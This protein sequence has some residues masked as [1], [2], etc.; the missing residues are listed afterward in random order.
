[1]IEQPPDAG[2]GEVGRQRQAAALLDEAARDLP[3]AVPDSVT[4]RL[5]LAGAVGYEVLWNDRRRLASRAGLPVARIEHLLDR[6]GSGTGEL[7]ALIAGDPALGEPIPGAA[8]YLRAEA[9]Y[10]VTHEGALHLDDVLARRTRIAI[11]ERDSGSGA[12]PAVAALVAGVLGWD[13][14]TVQRETERY[15]RQVQTERD[16][17]HR[18]ADVAADGV[19][20]RARQ[21]SRWPR[22][23]AAVSC[24]R[25]WSASGSPRSAYSVRASC[26]W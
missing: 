9:V 15:R 25:T 7:L 18:V 23:S 24:P 21:G 16:A 22:L 13:S 5:P 3:G 8:G 26:Q 20:D 11:E 6:Y 14:T 4:G 17:R 12:A 2:S 1:M 10:A 19:E